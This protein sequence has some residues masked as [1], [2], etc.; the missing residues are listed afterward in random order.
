[1]KTLRHTLTTLSLGLGLLLTGAASLT[2]GGCQ[3]DLFPGGP[4]GENAETGTRGDLTSPGNL[5]KE[6]NY[7]VADKQVPLV[8][9]GRVADDLTKGLLS[10]I[11]YGDNAS[12][13]CMFDDNLDNYAEMKSGAVG[14]GAIIQQAVTVKDLYRDYAG[15]Q[16]V[17]FVIN[18][19]NAALLTLDVLKTIY[20]QTYLNGNPQEALKADG[21]DEEGVLNLQLFATKNEGKQTISCMANEPFDE[22]Q[23]CFGGVSADVLENLQIYYAFVG[24]NEE[25]R[26]LSSTFPGVKVNAPYEIPNG[27]WANPALIT[28]ITGP[29]INAKV[30]EMLNDDLT[31]GPAFS[32]GA[33]NPILD[34]TMPSEQNI[35]AGS[36]I[37]FKTNTFN[38]LD[39][40]IGSS[41]E[42]TFT[43]V[44]DRT[45]T[46]TVDG[47]GIGASLLNGGDV[48]YSAIPDKQLGNIK[49][50]RIIFKGFTLLSGT[51][52][53]YAYYREPVSIDPST[54]F[55]VT[56]D[57]IN[58]GSTYRLPN[59]T[60][61][62]TSDVLYIPQAGNPAVTNIKT[63][64]VNG[65]SYQQVSGMTEDG[66]YRFRAIYTAPQSTDCECPGKQIAYDFYIYKET[67]RIPSCHTPITIDYYEN[68]KPI[69]PQ[70]EVSGGICILCGDVMDDGQYPSS[71]LTNSNTN[72]FAGYTAGISLLQNQ[73]I[74]AV[75]AGTT[76]EAGPKRVGFVLQNS[77]ELLGLSALNFYRI[78]LRDN[79]GKVIPGTEVS[80]ENTT[81]GL[82]LLGGEGN[83]IRYSIETEA[84]FRYVELYTSG[85]AD[86]NLFGMMRIYY[87]FWEDI[88]KDECKEMD[89]DILGDDCTMII[90]AAR[91]NANIY[92]KHTNSNGLAEVANT[93]ANLGNMI[94]E[95][96]HTCATIHSTEIA[97]T[98]EVGIKFDPI[99]TGQSIGVILKKTGNILDLG[100]L[101]TSI[102]LKTYYNGTET[103]D[104]TGG[105]FGLVGLQVISHG[106]YIYLEIFPKKTATSQYVDGISISLMQGVADVLDIIQIYGIYYR[107]DSDGN[108][109]IDCS[110]NPDT[111]PSEGIELLLQ[112]SN[113]CPGDAIG[114]ETIMH[115]GAAQPADGIYYLKC[116][117]EEH[118]TIIPVSIQDGKIIAATDNQ[119]LILTEDGIY[120]LRLYSSQT[121]A[122]KEN[123]DMAS[124]NAPILIV[125]PE[126]TE[127]TGA[128]RNHDWNTWGNW[129]KGT[130]SH[131]TNVIIP[132]SLGDNYPIL[133]ANE[134]NVCANL[135]IK[136]GGQLVNSFYLD[137]DQAWV[138]VELDENRYYMLTSPL[139]ATFSGD[140][141]I[142]SSISNL[143]A[144]D[145][146][147]SNS[148]PE[149]R[150][151]PTVYQRLWSTNAPVK[152]PSGYEAKDEVAPDETH[153]TPPYNGVAQEYGLGMGFSLMVKGGSGDNTFRFPKTHTEYN[154]FNLAG[155]ATGES[156]KITRGEGTIGRFIYE[157]ENSTATDGTITVPVQKREDGVT[158]CLVGN[159]FVAHVHLASFMQKNGI[160]EVKV[161]DGNENNSLI[162]VD[163][164]LVSSGSSLTYIKPMESFFVMNYTKDNVTYTADMLTAGGETRTRSASP[165]PAVLRLAATLDGH[166]A[167]ALLR[168]SPTASA[169]VVPGEDTKLLVEGEARPA[170]AIYTVADGRA[171]DIQQVPDDV[172]RIP[173][174]FYLPGGGKA[175][176]R[177][178][179]QFTD[180]EW[181]DWFLLDLRT[182]QRRRLTPAAIDL[183]DVENGSSRYVLVKNEGE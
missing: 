176:I 146:L 31:D 22:I 72:D 24:E 161:F 10:V 109:I 6:G 163:G 1:M 15:G 33:L 165:A 105:N 37:G 69:S 97:G 91:N 43:D 41:T 111:D 139:K 18:Q 117:S 73:G 145:Q 62:Q 8:G 130:P 5:H 19:S 126:E 137:Y 123:G 169:G 79:E 48:L 86:V 106:D 175:D 20:I 47:S 148:Y 173:L 77:Q 88:S 182:G 32:I 64:T 95:S 103:G 94:D 162:L 99:P 131:C 144:F 56:N 68:A 9:P 152:N 128:S 21:N 180:P 87:A 156:D 44:N 80:A 133:S 27:V 17:G 183:H 71:N 151:N 67:K 147:N 50:V 149:K 136:D 118:T 51:T 45:S 23:L 122:E 58:S 81:V 142:N 4:G 25:K 84:A 70:G 101:K 160:G 114:I 53:N 82:G 108:G 16:K 55:V 157:E 14:V 116:S 121:E 179:P 181:S 85:I 155:N 78:V 2:L 40:E 7:W 42:L 153:W 63:I 135:Y 28:P 154:Y 127:W 172:R 96:R 54:Y 66:F 167:H 26:I 174:G 75:D 12:L 36:E 92:Y 158:A 11:A 132:G 100:A 3:D 39:L 141:F 110:E 30:Q 112:T 171:L 59:P 93:M 125:H 29:A 168:V 164:Q 38:L 90:S 104:E 119:P 120:S 170:V 83:K 57:T 159:P 166:T 76:I 46:T 102:G 178:T 115:T 60:I 124:S 138:D 113:I 107:P 61:G 143:G 13:D 129:T 150:S 134:T 52:V 34:V 49:A 74:I 177:L 98:V 89:D 65:I 140:W 35:P